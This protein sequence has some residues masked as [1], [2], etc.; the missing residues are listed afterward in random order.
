M[1][2]ENEH[3]YLE[4]LKKVLTQGQL[5]NPVNDRTGVGRVS[6]FAERMEFNL[7]GG[8]TFPLITT[9]KVHLKSII[10]ELLWFLRGETNIKYLQDHR[11]RIWDEWA[12]EKGEVGRLYGSQWRSWQTGG[13]SPKIAVDQI[14]KVIHNI[15]TN[16]HSTRHIVSAWNVG[17]ISEMSLPPCHILFQFYVQVRNG[18]KYLSCQLNQRSADMFLGVPFN[19]ASY[20]LLTQMVA[21]VTGCIADRLI[22][23][24]G[25]VHIYMNHVEQVV[26]QL[27]R[28]VRPSSNMNLNP[29]VSDIDTF[30]YKDFKLVNYNPHPTIKGEVAI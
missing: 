2:N 15:K 6:L 28:E 7:S 13:K 30:E 25:D 20:A 23:V 12:D 16:P 8:E 5:V 19:I 14:G 24:I 18:K 10:H 3:Q 9:K 22:H 26:E 4:L 11:V 27:Q 17:E 29:Y 1:V 21:Q